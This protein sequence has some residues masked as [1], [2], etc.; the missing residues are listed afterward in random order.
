MESVAVPRI[1]RTAAAVRYETPFVHHV[2]PEAIDAE[3]ASAM[4]EWLEASDG[5]EPR[6]IDA[7]YNFFELSV[8]RNRPPEGLEFVTARPFLD[9]IRETCSALFGV[10]FDSAVT[11]AVHKLVEGCRIRVHTDHG[12]EP[13]TH[14]FL[15][16]L[17][18]GWD[19]EQGGLLLFLDAEHRT[20]IHDAHRYYLPEHR[21]AVGF[22]ISPR[23][24]HAV[25]EVLQGTRYTL[26]Y[27][28]RALT[29]QSM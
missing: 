15:L 7:F 21:L 22:E 6:E 9:E 10:A 19:S 24:Y 1:A 12:T 3:P 4:L 17:T 23:S 2:C 11:L 25:S 14:R 26:C 18:R 5:W 28:L 20:E 8:A 16:H 13:V 27:S 29:S